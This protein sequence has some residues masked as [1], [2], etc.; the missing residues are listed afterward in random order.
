MQGPLPQ[1]VSLAGTIESRRSTA[2]GAPK[3]SHGGMN[4]LEFD[5]ATIY[6]GTG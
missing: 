4:V 1:D 5:G 2:T 6:N 3:V